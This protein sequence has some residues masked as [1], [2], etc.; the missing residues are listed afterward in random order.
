MTTFDAD[1]ASEPRTAA[2]C[3]GRLSGRGGDQRTIGFG[4][5]AGAML[6]A[7]VSA[8]VIAL[9]ASASAATTTNETSN[10]T[11]T[12]GVTTT[13]QSVATSTHETSNYTSTPN[14]EVKPKSEETS[15]TKPQSEVKPKSEETSPTTASTTEAKGTLPFTG[16]NLA[17]VIGGGL[18]LLGLGVTLRLAQRR[19]S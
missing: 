7:L 6:G 2:A 1:Y 8:A 17:W 4:R 19:H 9:P 14:N 18:L 11:A 15:P 5:R 13:T 16:L 3:R 10:Y 12:P